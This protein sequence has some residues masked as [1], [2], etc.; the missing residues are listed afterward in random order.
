MVLKRQDFVAFK[1]NWN[2][3]SD[4]LRAIAKEL[5]IGLDSLV[6]VDDNPAEREEVRQA[7]PEVLVPEIAEDPTDYP[8]ALDAAR[9]FEVPAITAEDRQRSDMYQ[10]QRALSDLAASTRDLSEFLASLAMEAVVRPFEPLSLT[11]VTQLINKTNQF[12]LTTRRL[13]GAE[14]EELMRDPSAFTRTVRL[15][16]RFGDHGLISVLF[17]HVQAD[18]L[19][20]DGWLMSCRVLK[21]G[22]AEFLLNELVVAAKARGVSRIVGTYIPTSRNSMVEHHYRDLGFSAVDDRDGVT[23]WRLDVDDFEPLKTFITVRE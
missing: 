20:V 1:A 11:R 3:K 6:F 7:L 16:D 10:G 18:I 15:A 2:P 4:N 17:A 21:R 8:A 12:N 14:V 23:T 5:N 13:T 9:C 19:T 22:V